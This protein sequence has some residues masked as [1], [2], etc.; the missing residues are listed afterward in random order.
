MRKFKKFLE[1]LINNKTFHIILTITMII[2]IIIIALIIM[3]RYSIK[4]E[5]QIPFDISKIEVISSAGG[6]NIEDEQNTDR[7]NINVSQN[8]D[9]YIYLEKNK[10]FKERKQE[11]IS[12]VL[13]EN[14]QI[15]KVSENGENKIYKPDAESP[16]EL[17][18]N[19]YGK[20]VVTFK[21]TSNSSVSE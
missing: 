11:V 8:N 13:I 3:L 9:F 6:E 17:F 18:K 16:K 10:D 20:P 15:E 4:G 1:K 14:I 19:T 21:S 5:D 2:A 12:S 7:W